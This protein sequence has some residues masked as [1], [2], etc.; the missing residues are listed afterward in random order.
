M[1]KHGKITRQDVAQ[2]YRLGGPQAYRLL[3]RLVIQ[4]LTEWVSVRGRGVYYRSLNQ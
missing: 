3:Q 2:L 1:E 4:G